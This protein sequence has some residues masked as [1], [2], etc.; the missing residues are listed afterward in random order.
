[1][2][3]PFW[4]VVVQEY[5]NSRNYETA[6]PPLLTA[7]GFRISG[8]FILEKQSDDQASRKK[9]A[10]HF[11]GAFG[12]PRFHF[13]SYPSTG[14]NQSVSNWPATVVDGDFFTPRAKLTVP[15]QNGS[16]PEKAKSS[17]RDRKDPPD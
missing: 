2:C 13:A 6:Q 9:S 15:F 1:M 8:P 17:R 5:C 10:I 16:A 14:M 4:T 7:R 12:G 11:P 3:H